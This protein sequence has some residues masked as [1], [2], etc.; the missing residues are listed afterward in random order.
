MRRWTI[1]LVSVLALLLTVTWLVAQ[2]AGGKAPTGDR[3]PRD[4]GPAAGEGQ[5]NPPP[6]PD[7]ADGGQGGPGRRPPPPG[8]VLMV[9]LDSNHD[10]E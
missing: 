1:G 7:H 2:P 10:G 9:A 6:P 5:E 3:P 4:Q 8:M